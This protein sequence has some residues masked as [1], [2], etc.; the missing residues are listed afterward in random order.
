MAVRQLQQP[1]SPGFGGRQAGDDVGG[2]GA[3]LVAG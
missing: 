3:L 2:L 1:V